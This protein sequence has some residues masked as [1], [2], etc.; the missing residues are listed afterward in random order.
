MCD[1]NKS[2][3]KKTI[4][5]V[6]SNITFSSINGKDKDHDKDKNKDNDRDKDN[7]ND[8]DNDK[9]SNLKNTPIETVLSTY[10]SDSL[11]ITFKSEGT[12]L[13]GTFD[14]PVTKKKC[15]SILLVHGWGDIDR[16]GDSTEWGPIQNFKAFA[17]VFTKNGI[18]VYRYDKRGVGKSKGKKN[19]YSTQKRLL[20]K[21][22]VK[23]FNVMYLQN[24]VDKDNLF[25]LGQSQGSELITKAYE[26]IKRIVK[27][28]GLIFI[29]CVI[30]KSTALNIDT[31]MLAINGVYDWNNY[32]NVCRSPIAAQRNKYKF[33]SYYYIAPYC[34][35]G[36]FNMHLGKLVVKHGKEG[37]YVTDP[38]AVETMIKFIQAHS[39]QA[40]LSAI[41]TAFNDGMVLGTSLDA[42]KNPSKYLGKRSTRG[43]V[44]KGRRRD[45]IRP[46]G[47]L[48]Y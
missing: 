18:A 32:L 22:I 44:K 16:D 38:L 10:K 21:D 43:W 17:K 33:N 25:L 41:K 29:S 1:D 23:A 40:S 36:V 8:E 5:N 30:K 35:H 15:P 42:I 34:D 19:A 24:V 14:F 12:L 31:P 48:N 6:S 2:D 26:E 4:N 3:K 46:Q 7:D 13:E 20:I 28:K 39:G 9:E 45:P 37:P 11:L 47:V 27:P